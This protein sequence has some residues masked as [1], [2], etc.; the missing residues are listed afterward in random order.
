MSLLGL[1]LEPLGPTPIPNHLRYAS[2]GLHFDK[3]WEQVDSV[4]RKC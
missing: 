4:N 3:T 2:S 1:N